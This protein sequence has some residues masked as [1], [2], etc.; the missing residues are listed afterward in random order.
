MMIRIHMPGSTTSD[1]LQQ[2]KSQELKLNLGMKE[3]PSY[4]VGGNVNYNNHYRKSMKTPQ[5]TK[6]RTAI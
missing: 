1:T 4:T 3:E 2:T 6:N 5:K